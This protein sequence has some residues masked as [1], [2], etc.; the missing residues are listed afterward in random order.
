VNLAFA[1]R[2]NGLASRGLAR[3]WLVAATLLMLH[4]SASEI[5]VPHNAGVP[6]VSVAGIELED[7]NVQPVAWLRNILPTAG[8]DGTA[9]GGHADC[10]DTDS[11]ETLAAVAAAPLPQPGDALA[12]RFALAPSALQSAFARAFNPRGPPPAVS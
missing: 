8:V 10:A 7:R 9:A 2:F 4:W 1:D 5:G 6:D 3:L 11:T 12:T